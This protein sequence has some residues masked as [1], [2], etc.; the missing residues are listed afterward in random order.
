[1]LDRADRDALAKLGRRVLA[2][3]WLIALGV[4]AAFVWV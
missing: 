1:V 3:T 2:L 4:T